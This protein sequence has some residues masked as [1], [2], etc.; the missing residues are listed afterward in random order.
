MSRKFVNISRSTVRKN[1]RRM[2]ALDRFAIIP[3]DFYE[4]T[5]DQYADYVLRKNV[6]LQS[7]RRSLGV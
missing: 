4:G 2:R 3:H 6:E 7:L 1:N 5:P